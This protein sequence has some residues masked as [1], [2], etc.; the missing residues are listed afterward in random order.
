MTRFENVTFDAK[1][2]RDELTAFEK[3]LSKG[4]LEERKD[5]LPFFKKNRNLAA[6]IGAFNTY[7]SLFDKLAYELSLYGDFVCDMVTG[8]S[9]AHAYCFV[10]FEDAT[11]ESIFKKKQRNRTEWSPRFERGFGQLL[12]WMWKVD[13]QRLT[14]TF[15][16][17]FGGPHPSC[18]TLLIIGRTAHVTDSTDLSRFLWLRDKLVVDGRQIICMTY[19]DLLDALKN[20]ITYALGMAIDATLEEV[21]R[22]QST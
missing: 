15:A 9:K 13:E 22:Y 7:N 16:S 8:D 10:E 12:D 17:L 2:C 11:P 19:D 3:L 5:I 6:F 4:S 14:P 20:K 21:K 1:K 18:T